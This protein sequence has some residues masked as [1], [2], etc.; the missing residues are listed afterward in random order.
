VSA[1]RGALAGGL[2][3]TALYAV[4]STEGAANRTGTFFNLISG[5]IRRL[6]DPA[7]PLIPDRSGTHGQS[8]QVFA[9]A[10]S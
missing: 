7:V 2:G 9:L 8:T 1:L 10:S 4:V 3:L 6:V 5:A